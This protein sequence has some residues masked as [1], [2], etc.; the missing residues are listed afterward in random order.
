L[1]GQTLW[2][3]RSAF[4]VSSS[5]APQS[6]HRFGVVRTRR[7]CSEVARALCRF[8]VFRCRVRAAF[9]PAL[10]P[11]L[12]MAAADAAPGGGLLCAQAGGGASAST[13]A[14]P[15]EAK[16]ALRIVISPFASSATTRPRSPDPPLYAYSPVHRTSRSA[17]RQRLQEMRRQR[18]CLRLRGCQVEGRHG[19]PSL[20]EVAALHKC[21]GVMQPAH[22]H[23]RI[24]Q[25]AESG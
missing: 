20:A 7:A 15:I 4:E 19:E 1:A 10:A 18:I 24:D 17:L 13:R 6:D 12:G 3:R 5:F 23:A 25:S 9:E 14:T 21:G 11:V 16:I 2:R 22:R 8:R